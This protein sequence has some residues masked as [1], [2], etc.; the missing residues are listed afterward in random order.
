MR[1]KYHEMLLGAAESILGY[2]GFDRTVYG[3]RKKNRKWWYELREDR[4][5]DIETET[6]VHD[7]RCNWPLIRPIFLRV[8]AHLFQSQIASNCNAV[9]TAFPP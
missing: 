8:L 5:K 3:D 2:F 7:G 4:R 9:K 1:E 6:S